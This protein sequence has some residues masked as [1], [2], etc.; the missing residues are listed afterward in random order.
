MRPSEVL[1]RHRDE[2]KALLARYPVT[3]PRI[4]GSV[5]DGSDGEGSDLDILVDGVPGVTTLFDL[6]GLH[7]ELEELLG[8]SVDLLTPGGIHKEIRDK[9]LESAKPL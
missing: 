3:N 6:G 4:F 7:S 9:V 5:A 1:D 2:I 8:I